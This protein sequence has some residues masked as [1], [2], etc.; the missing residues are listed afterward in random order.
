MI[1]Q[2]LRGSKVKAQS[3]RLITNRLLTKIC[4]ALARVFSYFI[5]WRTAESIRQSRGKHKTL[6]FSIL[7]IVKTLQHQNEVGIIIIKKELLFIISFDSST[8]L[9]S[10]LDILFKL[11]I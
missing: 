7:L 9:K 6:F 8:L 3:S 10:T 2:I 11:I 5:T 1:I 4:M